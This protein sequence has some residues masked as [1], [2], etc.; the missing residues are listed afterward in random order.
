MQ[1]LN[2]QI[3]RDILKLGFNVPSVLDSLTVSMVF[4]E[5]EASLAQIKPKCVILDFADVALLT[6]EMLGNLIAFRQSCLDKGS[7]LKLC[8]LNDAL[9]NLLEITKLNTVFDCYPTREHAE[10][11]F[12][13]EEM[14]AD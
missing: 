3:E 5:L 9:T 1:Y 14:I 8:N 11:E 4:E 12:I 7:S 6:S 10:E 2:F 13:E